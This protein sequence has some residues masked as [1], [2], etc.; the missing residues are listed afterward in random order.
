MSKSKSFLPDFHAIFEAYLEGGWVLFDPTRLAPV[1]NLIRI[2][3]GVD[4]GDVAFSTFYGEV[5]LI[6]IEPIIRSESDENPLSKPT[7]ITAK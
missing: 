3:T 6:E 1:E 5:E 7:E 4:A 2:G